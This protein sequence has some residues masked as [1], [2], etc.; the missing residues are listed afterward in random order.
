MNCPCCEKPTHNE[1]D[2]PIC[3]YCGAGVNIDFLMKM[4]ESDSD[5]IEWECERC[6]QYFDIHVTI[7]FEVTK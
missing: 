5:I 2:Y 1:I 6:S 3:P 7:T 4:V